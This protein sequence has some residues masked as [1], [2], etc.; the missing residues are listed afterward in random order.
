M[1]ER[2]ST[3][4]FVQDNQITNISS[5]RQNKSGYLYCTFLNDEGEAENF[6]FS[7]SLSKNISAGDSPAVLK[8]TNMVLCDSQTTEGLQYWRIS[9]PGEYTSVN[10]IFG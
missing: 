1:Q 8:D 10:S 4:K 5:V 3:Q 2:M 9:S 6:Y 7:K